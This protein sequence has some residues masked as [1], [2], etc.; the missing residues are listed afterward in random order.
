[1]ILT[2]LAESAPYEALGDRIAAGLRWLR[3][4][5]EDIPDGRHAIDGDG[6]F[7]LVS[8][9]DTGPST[10]KRFETHVRHVDLQYVATGHER[11]LH[12]PAAALIVETPYDEAADIT[13]YAEPPFASSLL[14]R[15]GDLAIFHPGDA[16]KPGCMAGG[17]HAVRKVVVKVRI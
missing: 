4:M 12:T 13:F 16:H 5:N 9:Y 14:M 15:P 17:R 2:T 3:G 6:V 10:E 1:V 7:A 8:S 11:I